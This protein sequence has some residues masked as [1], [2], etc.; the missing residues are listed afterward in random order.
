MKHNH[1][2]C[3]MLVDNIQEAVVENIKLSAAFGDFPYRSVTNTMKDLSKFDGW[4]SGMFAMAHIN[5]RMA[6]VARLAEDY[7]TEDI[8]RRVIERIGERRCDTFLGNV[9]IDLKLDNSRMRSVTGVY[10]DIYCKS[11][12]IP[13]DVWEDTTPADRAQMAVDAA[14]YAEARKDKDVMAVIAEA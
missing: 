11:P 8:I 2:W 4:T 12:F 10:P 5:L 3:V 7:T 14:N 13:R 6:F 9:L 1:D